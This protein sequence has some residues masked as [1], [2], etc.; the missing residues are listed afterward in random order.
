MSQ[1][2]L[3][4]NPGLLIKIILMSPGRCLNPQINVKATLE[5]SLL[6]LHTAIFYGWPIEKKTTK[7]KFCILRSERNFQK[8]CKILLH[9]VM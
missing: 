4:T 6:C 8:V 7:E 2:L 3:I 5:P 9:V 1:L